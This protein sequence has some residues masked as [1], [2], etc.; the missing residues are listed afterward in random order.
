M[1]TRKVKH[2]TLA[3]I[4]NTLKE[5]RRAWISNGAAGVANYAFLEAL[6]VAIISIIARIA[7][8]EGDSYYE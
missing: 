7:K 3:Q 5:A 1:D 6:Y 4:E 2:M 8:L